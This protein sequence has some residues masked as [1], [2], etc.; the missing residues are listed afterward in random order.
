MYAI[1][2]DLVVVDAEEHHPKGVS[3]AYND[4]A[5]TLRKFGFER[6]QGS[7]YTNSDENM[8]NLFRAMNALK[9]LDWFTKSV[10]DIRAFRIEQWS[11]FTPTM[12][13]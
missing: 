13:Y 6:V 9:A 1:S 12:K 3:Q 11:D 2:F 7:L 4:I 10:R 5:T 8:A